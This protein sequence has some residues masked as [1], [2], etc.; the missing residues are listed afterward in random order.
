MCLCCD[1]TC[2]KSEIC[3]WQCKKCGAG[4]CAARLLI[5][6]IKH[7]VWCVWLECVNATRA[8]V[9]WLRRRSAMFHAAGAIWLVSDHTGSCLLRSRSAGDVQLLSRWSASFRLLR[10]AAGTADAAARCG[11]LGP[12]C[13]QRPRHGSV[14]CRLRTAAVQRSRTQYSGYYASATLSDAFV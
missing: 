4:H 10:A 3:S 8:V 7:R 1:S 12:L 14:C 6:L 9:Q 5:A 11:I 2:G 13:S